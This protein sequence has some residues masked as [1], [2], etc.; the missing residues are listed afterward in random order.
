MHG[1]NTWQ[2]WVK[3]STPSLIELCGS[4]NRELLVLCFNSTDCIVEVVVQQAFC[5]K[6]SLY[7]LVEDEDEEQQQHS[8]NNNLYVDLTLVRM[9]L[10]RLNFLLKSCP[11]GTLPDPQFL[12][13]ILFL[14]SSDRFNLSLS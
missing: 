14:V 12:S 11:P 6:T 1:R 3:L 13:T 2:A 8:L 10:L 9:G 7:F 5:P 4:G